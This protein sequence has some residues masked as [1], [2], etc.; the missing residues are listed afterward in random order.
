MQDEAREQD[1]VAGDGAV[2]RRRVAI[3]VAAGLCAVAL[4]GPGGW[5]MSGSDSADPAPTVPVPP[6]APAPPTPPTPPKAPPTAPTAPKPPADPDDGAGP[7][8]WTVP[9]RPVPTLPSR[10]VS[11]P[12]GQVA[13]WDGCHPLPPP[14]TLS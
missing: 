8:Q 4:V 13:S 1:Q 6:V 3:G 14:V 12:P 5:A 7:G 11:C 9:P 2:R 10:P